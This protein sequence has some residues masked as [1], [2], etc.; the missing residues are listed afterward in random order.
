M[1]EVKFCEVMWGLDY[2]DR[3]NERAVLVLLL[4]FVLLS[5]WIL[6]TEILVPDS[7]G[8]V[9]YIRSLVFDGDIYFGNEFDL[10]EVQRAWNHLSETGYTINMFAIGSSMLWAPFFGIGHITAYLSLIHI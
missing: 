2:G 7:A 10:L 8:Y 6:D 5:W 9:A 4:A 3:M 1:V